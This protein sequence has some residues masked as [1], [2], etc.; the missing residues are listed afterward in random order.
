MKHRIINR[1]EFL[2]V[3][4]VS[5][6][7]VSGG[8]LRC[9]GNPCPRSGSSGRRSPRRRSP[10][11]EAPVEEAPAAEAPAGEPSGK[12][13]IFS[14]WTSGGEVEALNACFEVFNKNPNVEIVN[15]AITGGTSSG[16]DMK[17]VLQTRMMGGDPPESFQVHLGGEL[18]ATPTWSTTWSN[19]SMTCTS[20]GWNKVFP[21]GVDRHRHVQ[22]QALRG[23]GQHPPRQ[24]AV[25]Q[26]KTVRRTSAPNRPQPGTTSSPW[27]RS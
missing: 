4:A 26:Q 14:W 25:V 11:E 21:K 16:G 7:T 27:P 12:L 3:G 22:G 13:E 1:R 15:T 23:A 10:A 18:P 5:A 20:E 2:K 8:S 17:A 9:T 19:R 24:H 6:A